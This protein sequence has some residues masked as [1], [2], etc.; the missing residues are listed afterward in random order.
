MFSGVKKDWT[1]SDGVKTYGDGN[2]QNR[3]SRIDDAIKKN[4][5]N[6]E[7]DGDEEEGPSGNL[8]GIFDK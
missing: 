6:K 4:K 8:F 7:K 5:K 3:I 1:R 2:Y